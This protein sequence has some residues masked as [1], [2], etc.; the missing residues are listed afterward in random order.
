MQDGGGL[1]NRWMPDSDALAAENH[2]I[3]R[4]VLFQIAIQI[5]D[6]RLSTWSLMTTLVDRLLTGVAVCLT[7]FPCSTVH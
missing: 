3:G 1:S 2:H 6:C 7:M 4:I 5:C